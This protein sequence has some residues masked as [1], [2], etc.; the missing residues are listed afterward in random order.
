MFAVVTTSSHISVVDG[1]TGTYYDIFDFDGYNY[2]PT[3]DGL[4]MFVDVV[5]SMLNV[6]NDDD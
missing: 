4:D 1:D 6:T 5:N 3:V 2:I